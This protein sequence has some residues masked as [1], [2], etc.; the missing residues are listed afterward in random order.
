MYLA[1]INLLFFALF[2]SLVSLA[3][4][5]Q[6]FLLQKLLRQHL[7]QL[8]R[9]L[10]FLLLF[11]LLALSCLFLPDSFDNSCVFF[12]AFPPVLVTLLSPLVNS[13]VNPCS[14]RKL[15][16]SCDE[17]PALLII[18]D[19]RPNV[20]LKFRFQGKDFIKQR[21]W[22]FLKALVESLYFYFGLCWLGARR[23]LLVVALLVVIALGL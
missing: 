12:T 13:R 10:F 19:H 3:F 8:G 20:A 16:I 5:L 15:N 21:L 18:I 2:F 9:L 22:T 14:V 7:L 11:L 23:M 6:E 4:L 1:F 17:T